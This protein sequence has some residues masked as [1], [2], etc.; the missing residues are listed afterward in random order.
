M[1]RFMQP[2]FRRRARQPAGLSADQETALL[3]IT[4]AMAQVGAHA[5]RLGQWRLRQIERALAALDEGQSGQAMDFAGLAVLPARRIP[6]RERRAALRLERA[7]A[8]A[9]ILASG[10]GAAG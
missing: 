7:L 6:V 9:R 4:Q 3:A 10:P 2:S 8:Y 1:T 5:D